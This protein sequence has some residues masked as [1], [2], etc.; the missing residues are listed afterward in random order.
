MADQQ[1]QQIKHGRPT[2]PTNK[3]WPTNKSKNKQTLTKN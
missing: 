2:N 1:I 3:T